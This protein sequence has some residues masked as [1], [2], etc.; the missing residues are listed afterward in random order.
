MIEKLFEVRKNKFKEHVGVIPELDL[1]EDGDKITHKMSLKDEMNPQD[2]E[3]IFK[4]DPDFDQ[5]EAEWEAIKREIL[6]EEAERINNEKGLIREEEEEPEAA[7]EAEIE[8]KAKVSL[9]S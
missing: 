9:D 7:E 6:G 5:N 3:N 8:P 1:V 4:F 2:G